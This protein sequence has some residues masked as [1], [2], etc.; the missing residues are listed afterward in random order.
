MKD[1]YIFIIYLQ[2]QLTFLF[3]GLGIQDK[4]TEDK[5]SRSHGDPELSIK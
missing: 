5:D 3:V 1:K 4:A 2:L